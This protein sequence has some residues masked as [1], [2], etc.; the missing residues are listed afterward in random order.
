MPMRVSFLDQHERIVEL[1]LKHAPWRLTSWL[2][3]H[4]YIVEGGTLEDDEL[5]DIM[6]GLLQDTGYWD[7][8]GGY[9]NQYLEIDGYR[10]WAIGRGL[11]RERLPI[12][13]NWPGSRS[14]D[15]RE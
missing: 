9:R 11:N 6:L 3:P 13:T 8:Y 7:T 15:T 10:Y 1:R 4:E 5:L 14:K 2:Q 12:S